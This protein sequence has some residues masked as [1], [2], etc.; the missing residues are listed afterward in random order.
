MAN[1]FFISDHHF[2]HP[3]M[4]RL[5]G[6]ASVEAMDEHMVTLHNSVVRQQD[7]VYFLGDVAMKRQHLHIVRR[8][9]GH[10]RLVFGNHDIFDY[11]EYAKAGFE[12]LMGYRV[13]DG[14]IFS[15]IPL[16]SGQLARF[17]RNVHGHLHEN[18]VRLEDG[19]SDGRYFSVCVERLSYRPMPLEEIRRMT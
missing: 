7:H 13:M 3:L 10:K 8:L 2:T 4:A 5:R 19:Q 11:Q 6:F 1:L 14:I 16:G 17:K 9:N 18:P 15:H 12:K